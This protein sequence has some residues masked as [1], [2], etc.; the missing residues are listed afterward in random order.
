MLSVAPPKRRFCR[1]LYYPRFLR[2]TPPPTLERAVG[3][4]RTAT[5]SVVS[6]YLIKKLNEKRKK[7]L[8]KISFSAGGFARSLPDSATC[9]LRTQRS[10]MCGFASFFASSFLTATAEC[11]CYSPKGQNRERKSPFH[12]R[13]ADMLSTWDNSPNYEWRVRCSVVEARLK[14]GTVYTVLYLATTAEELAQN[15]MSENI[16]GIWSLAAQAHR[17]RRRLLSARFHLSL[18]L[19][20]PAFLGSVEIVEQRGGGKEGGRE[21][22]SFIIAAAGDGGDGDGRQYTLGKLPSFRRF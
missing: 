5:Q 12:I 20:R 13:T 3:Q 18:C 10:L 15:L 1:F 8:A 22:G 19:S 17:R 16:P 4:K 21:E 14:K 9:V 2:S 7:K 11:L 6:T